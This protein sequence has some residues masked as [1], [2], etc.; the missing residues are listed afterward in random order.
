MFVYWIKKDIIE[1]LYDITYFGYNII[2]WL[3]T[4]DKK[5][6]PR[7]YDIGPFTTENSVIFVYIDDSRGF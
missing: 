5:M 1:I 2:K 7:L 6:T 3:G 4:N